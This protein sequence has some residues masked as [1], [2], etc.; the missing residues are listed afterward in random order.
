MEER[1]MKKVFGT[2]GKFQKEREIIPVPD[3]MTRPCEAMKYF[4]CIRS[5]ARNVIRQGYYI[6]DYHKATKKPGTLTMTAEE[7]YNLAWS[8]FHRAFATRIPWY[9]DTVEMVQ[10]GVTGLLER[11]GDEKFD[12]PLFRFYICKNA[13][14]N[15]FRKQV[16]DRHGS[17]NID[18]DEVWMYVDESIDTWR[19]KNAQED[20]LIHLIDQRAA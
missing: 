9:I 10:E 19:K 16:R 3:G 15:F 18:K 14:R 6:V 2:P 5:T 7:C 11:A 20:L 8:I 1:Q 13:M 4:G 17:V 12:K